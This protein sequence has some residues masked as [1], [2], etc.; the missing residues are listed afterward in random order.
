[1]SSEKDARTEREKMLAGVPYRSR[2]PEL[3]ALH[4]RA[5]SLIASFRAVASS[6]TTQK[7]TILDELLGDVGDDV[8]IEAPF[9]CDYG[10]HITIGRGVFVNYNCVFLDSHRITIGAHT[11]IGPSVQVYTTTH[12]LP[13]QERIRVEPAD[14]DERTYYVTRAQPVTIGE[15]AWI[16]GG[17]LIMP[18]VTIGDNTT[19]GAGSVVTKSIPPDCFAAGNPCTVVRPLDT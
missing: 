14:D 8:W 1:M 19:I 13:A 3:L 5:Q 18:G 9:F 17:A 12:P 15:K 7:R 16:G 10:V 11:L 6:D 2:D 4:H